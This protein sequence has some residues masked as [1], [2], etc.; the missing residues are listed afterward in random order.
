MEPVVK[1]FIK[2]SLLWLGLGVSLGLVMAMVPSW[3]Q[4]R[5]AHLHINLLGFVAMMI[6]G[7]AYHVMPRFSGNPL[8]HRGLTVVH[9]WLANVGLALLVS[10][11]AARM[12]VGGRAW[13]LLFAGGLASV[14]G[15][16]AFI[17][18]IW[19]TLDGRR[20][21]RGLPQMRDAA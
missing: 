4:Y 17:Y 12:H 6:F 1:R 14:A 13:P 5:T 3:A 7:V 20:R 11:F 8:H 16:Y 19:R 10:G 9:F 18:N 2:T 21:P 15:A